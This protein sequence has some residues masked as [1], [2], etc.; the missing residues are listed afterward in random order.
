MFH[1]QI[2]LMCFIL[3]FAIKFFFSLT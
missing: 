3:C 1:N 2:V